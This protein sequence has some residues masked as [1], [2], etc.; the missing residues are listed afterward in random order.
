MVTVVLVIAIATVG[1]A[2]S[3]AARSQ[4][5]STHR[6]D[7]LLLQ[8]TLAGLAA[9]YVKSALQEEYGFASMGPWS[10]T[11]GDAADEARLEGF[12][13]RSPVHNHGAVLLSLSGTP[14]T[15]FAREP[16]LPPPTDPGYIPMRR[17]LLTGHPGLSSVMHV[18]DVD[19]VAAAVPVE[20]DGTRVALLVTFSR[21]SGTPLQTNAEH[22]DFGA[23]ALGF[24]VDSDGRAVAAGRPELV[25]KQ[26]RSPAVPRAGGQWGT[27]FVS[28]ARDGRQMVSSYS[29]IGIGGWGLVAEQSK[30]AFYGP[31]EASARRVQLSM[32]AGLV[33][34]SV[35]LLVVVRRRHRVLRR[36]AAFRQLLNGVASAANEATGLTGLLADCFK[37][38]CQHTGWPVGHVYLA[39]RDG[40]ADLE[41]SAIWHLD[42]PKRYEAFRSATHATTFAPG[43]GLLGRAAQTGVA[44]WIPDVASSHDFV[45]WQ[46]DR[47]LGVR[48]AFAF[49]VMVDG[50]AVAV[51]EFFSPRRARPDTRLI[52]LTQHIAT[53]VERVARR[54]IAADELRAREERTRQILDTATDAFVSI[55]QGGVVTAWN[56]QAESIFGWPRLEAIGQP[57]TDLIVAPEDRSADFQELVRFLATDTSSILGRRLE[58]TGLHRF[59]QRLLMELTISAV[60]SG[61]QISFNAF[62]HDIS[63]RKEA[64][65]RLQ[66][67]ALHDFLTGLPNRVLIM[68]R[69]RVALARSR[70]NDADVALLFLDLDDFKAVNDS[71]GHD[72]GDEL[73]II[74]ADRLKAVLRPSDTAGRLGGDEF[75]VLCDGVAGERA[76]E[77]LV[78]RVEHAIAQ[79]ANIR[80][81]YV[82]IRVS[83]G[84]AVA[85]GGAD[86]ESLLHQADSAMYERKKLARTQAV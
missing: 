2:A 80:G 65:R 24:V 15:S 60:G 68:D 58:L 52:E 70:R 18:G 42:D 46:A 10:L 34:A 83:I 69:L 13:K 27:G 29:P 21:I 1:L 57:F 76:V 9:Q 81:V 3:N 38:V 54:E 85:A 5:A 73:L 33:F 49:P 6:H 62:I 40:D 67:L 45:R 26:V 75:V 16:G 41:P 19:L 14:L 39:G 23:T 79:P 44:E 25:G 7:R 86:A 36:E 59:G 30:K 74:V 61:D 43:V 51:F 32:L 17:S 84:V 22:L 66:V 4:A 63:E 48:G 55:D 11:P 82:E 35:A 12:V 28:F 77:G 20:V 64:E 72:A 31:L 50:R 47:D 8:R 56:L 78:R 71:L 53:Q 37:M